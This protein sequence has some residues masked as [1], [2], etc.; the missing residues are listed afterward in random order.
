[1]RED[2]S[3]LFAIVLILFVYKY[4]IQRFF[5]LSDRPPHSEHL[6]FIGC[7]F[8]NSSCY[9]LLKYFLRWQYEDQT[10]CEL[11]YKK[12]TE[13]SVIFLGLWLFPT[14]VWQQNR[15]FKSL[16]IRFIFSGI[17]EVPSESANYFW[18][19]MFILCHIQLFQV[20]IWIQRTQAGS[21]LIQFY[22]N[23]ICR[24]SKCSFC[25]NSCCRISHIHKPQCVV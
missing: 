22:K 20:C 19:K 10:H 18:V 4:I 14:T 11:N 12:E 6:S 1:M 2:E 9:M 5:S 3:K 7:D 23:V 8:W 13:G 16:N 21:K 24:A 15:A 17:L 25:S